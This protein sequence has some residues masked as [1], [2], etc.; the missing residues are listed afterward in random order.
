MAI[1]LAGYDT[2]ATQAVQAFWGNRQQARQKQIEAGK[3]DQ[4]ERAGVTAGKNMD[5]FLAL[6]MDI[7][8]ANGLDHAEIHQTRRVLTLPGYFRPTK[9][10]D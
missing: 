4:G 7:V 10:W 5:G 2:K 3:A 9:L 1:D 8:R 6:V